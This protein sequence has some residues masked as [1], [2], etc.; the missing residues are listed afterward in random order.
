[1]RALL[2][3]VFLFAVSCAS[4]A[5]KAE[6]DRASNGVIVSGWMVSVGH[7]GVEAYSSLGYAIANSTLE[8]RVRTLKRDVLD[9]ISCH[10][11]PRIEGYHVV[12]LSRRRLSHEEEDKIRGFV[13]ES[14]RIGSEKAHELKKG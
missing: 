10:I 14:L 5:S 1:M 12:I 13:D 9:D 2:T 8:D 6:Q 11:V 3:A 4:G 7:L